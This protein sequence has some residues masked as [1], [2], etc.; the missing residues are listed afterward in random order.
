[1]YLL[2]YCGHHLRIYQV[3]WYTVSVVDYNI[4]ARRKR[5]IKLTVC[6]AT[7][8][9]NTAIIILNF[10]NLKLYPYM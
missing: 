2:W 8:F 9:N 1:M 3:T 6:N 5:A 7:A 4:K 10:K